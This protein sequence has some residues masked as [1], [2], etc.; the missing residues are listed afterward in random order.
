MSTAAVSLAQAYRHC[1]TV[2]RRQAR[3]F[4]Y[5]FVTLPP[6]QRRAIYA[7]YAF[8]RL[9]DDVTDEPGL[10]PQ[11][12]ATALEGLR[13][14]LRQT[15]AGEPP[16]PVFTAL[17][18]AARTFHIPQEYFQEIIN[19]VAMDLRQRRYKTF[20]EL[21]RYCYGVA[22]TV[23]LV[24]IQVFGYTDPKAREYAVDLG[25]AMQLT[26]ILR[27]LGE[28]ARRGRIYL[29]QEELARF[30]YS[31]EELLAGHVSDAFRRLM[32]FQVERARAYFASGRRLL[33]LLHPR[34]RACVA[35][36][37]GLYGRILD[38]I[39][40]RGYDVFRRRVSL[41]PWE[42]AALTLRLWLPSLVARR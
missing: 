15:Y 31:E 23:G 37:Q 10:S 36:L 20:E 11:E 2:T 34:S 42:K 12:Q 26:N 4:Y 38:R 35:V 6:R 40:E 39:E 18:D 21:R 30:G 1:R 25:L 41:S 13:Q 7:A 29:P 17:L 16:G 27:D 5:A 33:P 19:G 9:C 24:C 28:D 22:S 32:A 14:Q 3:N 8:C